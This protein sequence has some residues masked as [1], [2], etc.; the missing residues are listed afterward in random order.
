MEKAFAALDIQAQ[1][2]RLRVIGFQRDRAGCVVVAASRR[3]E[4]LPVACSYSRDQWPPPSRVAL[5]T[6]PPIAFKRSYVGPHDHDG[7]PQPVLPPKND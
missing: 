2:A 3:A 4:K 7:L 6:G 1:A 5:P